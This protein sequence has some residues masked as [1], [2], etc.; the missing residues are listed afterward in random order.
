MGIDHIVVDNLESN[1]CRENRNRSNS[2]GQ[3]GNR[4]NYCKSLGGITCGAYNKLSKI[5]IQSKVSHR[6]AMKECK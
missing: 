4:S 2:C 3:N 6:L 1:R 5:S